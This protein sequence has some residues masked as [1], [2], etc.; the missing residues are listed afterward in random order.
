MTISPKGVALIKEFEGC[1]LKAYSDIVGVVTIGYGHTGADVSM[2]DVITQEEAD[3]LLKRDLERFEAGVAR[4][5][6]VPVTQGQFD[7]LVCFAFN[8]G[9][10]AFSSSTLLKKVNSNDPTAASEFPRWNRAGSKVVAG[11]TRRR[12]AEQ[13]LFRS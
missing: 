10:A 4:M 6:K 12:L 13:A 2:G 3:S 1:S 8:L 5:L 9:L 11:L 7:A